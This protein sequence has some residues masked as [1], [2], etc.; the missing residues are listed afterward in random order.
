MRKITKEIA[1]AFLA[2]RK[3]SNGATMT[4]GASLY[5]HGTRKAGCESLIRAGLARPQR[6]D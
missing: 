4:N 5:L 2:K 6:K 3:K 1:A